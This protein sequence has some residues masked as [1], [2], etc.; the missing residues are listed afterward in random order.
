MNRLKLT[1]ALLV[2]TLGMN[3][4]K[5]QTTFIQE[6][7]GKTKQEIFSSLNKWVALNYN[8]AMNVIQL[9]DANGGSIIVKGINTLILPNRVYKAMLPNNPSISDNVEAKLNHVLDFSVKEGR[10]RLSFSFS[11]G[12]GSSLGSHTLLPLTEDE[13]KQRLD[14]PTKLPF[15]SKKKELVYEKLSLDMLEDE[16]LS[17]IE[18]IEQ[19]NKSVFNEVSSS[20][21]TEDW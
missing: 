19:T 9:S 8:S 13:K 7:E 11:Y 12:N 1:L 2:L 16:R 20:T 17:I 18:F 5:T 10:Y 15:T 14:N 6:V 3:A 21:V 4:Q